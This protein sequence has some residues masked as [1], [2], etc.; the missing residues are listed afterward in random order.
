MPDKD[1]RDWLREIKAASFPDALNLLATYGDE[2]WKKG[3]TA[4][5]RR[6][7]DKGKTVDR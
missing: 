2:K 1:N 7:Y 5:F 3:D 6:G 4:G